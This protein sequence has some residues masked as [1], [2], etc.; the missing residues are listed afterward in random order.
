ML[1]HIAAHS[2]QVSFTATCLADLFTFR[3]IQLNRDLIRTAALLH[4]ITK[5]KSL[6]TGEDH[7][8]TGGELL[9]SLGYAKVGRIVAQHVR[10]NDPG[11]PSS[12]P[13]EEEIVNYADKRVL[14]DRIESLD[15]RRRYIL[16]RYGTEPA[17][18][19]MI[20]QM[21]KESFALEKRLFG[22]LGYAPSS[23]ASLV[24]SVKGSREFEAY[25]SCAK[26]LQNRTTEIEQLS[27]TAGGYSL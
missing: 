17:R 16:E 11:D 21:F 8:A 7:A 22:L 2:I 14:H 20:H 24:P 9:V 18:R 15:A 5:T 6:T 1:T 13:R 25:L 23:L 3:G 12:L 19:D 10:L 27:V 4:D 26:N